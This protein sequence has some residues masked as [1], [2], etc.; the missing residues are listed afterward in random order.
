MSALVDF[1]TQRRQAARPSSDRL[2]RRGSE[3]SS[4]GSGGTESSVERVLGLVNVRNA[5]RPASATAKSA[6]APA[7]L[8]QQ[9]RQGRT[10]S[11]ASQ[12]NSGSSS[13][14]SL[15]GAVR[16][17]HGFIGAIQGEWVG[18]QDG[19]DEKLTISFI[20][21][22]RLLSSKLEVTAPG[23]KLIDIDGDPQ[24]FL[25]SLPSVYRRTGSGSA[26][27]TPFGGFLRPLLGTWSGDHPS[28][29][30]LEISDR[31]IVKMEQTLQLESSVQHGVLL[32]GAGLGY[33]TGQALLV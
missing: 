1:S 8:S 5:L 13:T 7:D 20:S 4:S 23:I 11:N 30:L 25:P 3:S 28:A 12:G 19:V 27:V 15:S 2:R 26:P 31:G 24:F 6:L 18:S 10:G 9:R 32:S 33:E 21:A 29:P 17:Q 22:H 14:V 16:V